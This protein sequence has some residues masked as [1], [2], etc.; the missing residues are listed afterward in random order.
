M[1]APGPRASFAL[2]AALLGAAA[3]V[4]HEERAEVPGVP[5]S[6]D[7]LAVAEPLAAAL[8]PLGPLRAIV[9]SVLWVKLV[10]SELAG[11]SQA[12]S[13]VTEGLL[14][15]HPDLERVREHLAS[16]LIVNRAPQAPDGVRH[17][18][19][20]HRGLSMLEDGLE[21]NDSPNLHGLIGRIV[22]L[23]SRHDPRFDAA[24]RR[25]F[26]SDPGDVAIDELRLGLDTYGSQAFLA[27]LLVDRGLASW[28]RDED[29][30]A[31]VRDLAEAEQLIRM[32]DTEDGLVI[33]NR[34]AQL[35]RG[36]GMEQDP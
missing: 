30:A 34:I 29:V 20:V 26:G 12:M 28:T 10:R 32:M 13:L 7:A 4:P 36:I 18:A 19:L 14:A 9:S 5:S 2:G 8:A 24:A 22:A 6:D 17:R 31:A 15:I 21:L 35:K 25:F 16:D 27:D 11:D 1:I 23:Q 33:A 3:F